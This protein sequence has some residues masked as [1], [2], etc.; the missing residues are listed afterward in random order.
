MELA[1]LEDF[2]AL[3]ETGNFTRAANR[4]NLSQPAFS[5]RIQALERW[6]GAPLVIRGERGVMLTS[7]GREF[8]AD[9]E[10]V[11]RDIYRLRKNAMDTTARGD[12][13]LHFA[14]THS[15]SHTFFPYWIGRFEELALTGGL[16]LISDTMAACEQALLQGKAQ[17]LLCH[18][19]PAAPSCF[20]AGSFDFCRIGNDMLIPLSAPDESG[21][22]L[23]ELPGTREK[24]VRYLRYSAVSGLGRILGIHEP[25]HSCIFNPN[26]EFTSHLASVLLSM[27]LEGKG[28]AWLP[29][30]LAWQAI[31]DGRLMA[32]GCCG[33][34]DIPLEIRLH[35]A[36]GKLS[37]AAEAF[38]RWVN[39]E[40]TRKAEP[41]SF[42]E[43]I[44][45]WR[46]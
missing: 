21:R 17:F 45:L 14:A 1:W 31:K 8:M 36:S 22:P 43:S 44:N 25:F 13:T 35:R 11:I 33:V 37:S 46:V 34:W 19:H 26:P 23:W 27:T 10:A 30:T 41:G 20:V 18:Y 7:A 39:E 32:A 2:A 6:L 12:T 42:S 5:R 24:P 16:Y 40:S 15:L 3:V 28:V 29:K 38:W 9:A 4:R